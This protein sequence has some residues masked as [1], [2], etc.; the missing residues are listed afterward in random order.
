MTQL[1]I[2]VPD[3]TIEKINALAT[4]Y[5]SQAQVVIVAVENLYR[6]ELANMDTIRIERTKSKIFAKTQMKADAV[7]NRNWRVIGEFQQGDQIKTES[8]WKNAFDCTDAE[9][10]QALK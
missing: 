3:L 4:T 7:G 6:K 10:L 1:N 8:G 5:G 2:R 9:I